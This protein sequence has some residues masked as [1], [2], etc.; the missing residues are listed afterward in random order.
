MVGAD[1]DGMMG[2]NPVMG[3]MVSPVVGRK[4]GIDEA[5]DY[6]VDLL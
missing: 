4:A 3:G 6:W 5:R 1:N 2:G